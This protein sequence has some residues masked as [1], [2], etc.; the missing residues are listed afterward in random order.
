MNIDVANGKK[1]N[2][3]FEILHCQ[4]LFLAPGFSVVVYFG[5]LVLIDSMTF[6]S[7]FFV[8]VRTQG[9]ILRFGPGALFEMDGVGVD[10]LA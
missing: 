10:L 7:H 4:M 6:S 1:R 9:S 3:I 8:V 5:F 2:G